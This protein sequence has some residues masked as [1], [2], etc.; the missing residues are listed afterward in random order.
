MRILRA[1]VAGVFAAAAAT[2]CADLN[3]S[4]ENSPDAG[5]A[6]ARPSDVEALVG[7]SYF[8]VH[9]A[10][11]G[12]AT[13]SGGGANDAIQPQAIVFG[14]ESYSNL[15]NF[16]MGIRAAIPRTPVD[17]NRG[18]AVLAGN[19][20]DWLNLHKAARQAAVGLARLNDP[21]F[22]FFPASA[23][24]K[25]RDRAFA[26]FVIGAA[27]GDVAL[28]YD[29]G[30]PVGPNDPTTNTPLAMMPYDSLMMYAIREL[31]SA[32]VI[33]A[34]GTAS[35]PTPGSWLDGLALTQ[36]QFIGFVRGYRAR[37][38]AGVAR[39]PV[40][41]AA[42]RW[43][44]VIPDA[45]AAVAAFPADVNLP[46]VRANGWDVAWPIQHYASNSTNWHMMWQFMM[47]MAD[48]SGGY[49][50]WLATPQATR[51]AFLVVTPDTRFPAGTTRNA[52]TLASCGSLTVCGSALPAGLYIR[53][54]PT[55]LDWAGDPLASSYYDH[56][57]FFGFY[58]AGRNGNYPVMTTAEMNM[59]VAEGYIRNNQFD[60]AVALINLTR[61]AHGLPALPTGMTAA[62][63]IPGGPNGCVPKFTTNNSSAQCGTV[64]EAM[65]WEKRMETAYTG[66]YMWYVDSRGWGDLPSGTALMWP[67]PYQEIDTRQV[68]ANPPP[69]TS[70][71]GG[72]GGTASAPVGTYGI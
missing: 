4:N 69:Y 31:D 30:A 14:M 63:P 46:I 18:N 9:D 10:S 2:A 61:T 26:H 13:A 41:R 12:D 55:G 51:A 8:S 35:Y 53:N 65:K 16:G 70:S 34:T 42:V 68:G 33:A 67:T 45:Q 22:T 57:R 24:Q 47:G 54:R 20:R 6:L 40:D 23:T 7:S 64:L 52:Q 44:S 71:Y 39:T 60:Q 66:P 72:V 49:Q 43:D 37:F 29:Q 3:V 58:L 17:N 38:R 28:I 59:L 25:A 62:T 21:A 56:Y 1:F 19:Y 15:A 36:A 32:V 50:A 11:L 5:R 27:L 48:T